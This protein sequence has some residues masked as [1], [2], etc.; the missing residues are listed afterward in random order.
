MN[1]IHLAAYAAHQLGGDIA[2]LAFCT[3]FVKKDRHQLGKLFGQV[4]DRTDGM[5][6][7]IGDITLK[8]IGILN[9]GAGQLDIDDQGGKESGTPLGLLH[10]QVKPDPDIG[11]MGRIGNGL[12][13]FIYTHHIGILKAEP[14]R[15]PE[16]GLHQARIAP[17]KDFAANNL[18][19]LQR[20][21]RIFANIGLEQLKGGDKKLLNLLKALLADQLDK[22]PVDLAQGLFMDQVQAG[23]IHNLEEK[24]KLTVL[25]KG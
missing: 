21:M 14:N 4:I 13:V 2:Q 7:Q 22:G 11:Q 8:E 3:N 12:P 9:T 1:E 19:T 5:I 10:D 17:F 25:N 15:L 20:G 6:E 24:E 18:D 16:K 23:C